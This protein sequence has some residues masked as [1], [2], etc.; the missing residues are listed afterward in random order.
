MLESDRN[1][2]KI[3]RMRYACCI[4]E[5][6]DA[7]SE[8]LILLTFPRK[9]WFTGK[10]LIIALMRTLLLLFGTLPMLDEA[11]AVT[12]FCYLQLYDRVR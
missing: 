5:A 12:A 4:T 2:M 6:T 8:Y 11:T 10:R 1:H 3:R 9:Q 7:Y